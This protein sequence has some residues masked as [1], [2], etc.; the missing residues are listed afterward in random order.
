MF[1][2]YANMFNFTTI[3]SLPPKLIDTSFDIGGQFVKWVD[4]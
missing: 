2:E 3:V 1:E 4:R